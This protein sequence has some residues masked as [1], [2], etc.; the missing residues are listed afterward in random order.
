MVT[1]TTYVHTYTPVMIATTAT[2][3]SLTI[4]DLPPA[5]QQQFSNSISTVPL[6]SHNGSTTATSCLVAAKAVSSLTHTPKQLLPTSTTKPQL[7]AAS[8]SPQKSATLPQPPQQ[9]LAG[10]TLLQQQ[11]LATST[12]VRTLPSVP[13][14]LH[15]QIVQGDYIDFSTVLSKTT[16]IL[17]TP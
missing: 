6:Y 13:T 17:W 9:M 15:Q 11:L 10:P 1:S 4:A 8:L 5:I 7:L 12:H 16:L 14:Q 3:S 2:I